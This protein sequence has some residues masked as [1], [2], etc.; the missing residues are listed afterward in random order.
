MFEFLN[1]LL[2]RPSIRDRRFER[3]SVETP[4]ELV[5]TER[6]FSI[7]GMVI[8][9]SQGGALFREAT[10]YILDRKR[11]LVVLRIGPHEFPGVIVNVRPVGYGIL[12]DAPVSQDTIMEIASAGRQM[13]DEATAA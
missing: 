6:R 2:K 9:L 13:A 4:A 1:T 10:R 12:F 7:S 8:E 5:F 3:I 11:A